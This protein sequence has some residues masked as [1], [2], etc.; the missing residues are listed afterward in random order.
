[1]LRILPLC[2]IM[3][4]NQSAAKILHDNLCPPRKLVLQ[5]FLEVLFLF[6]NTIS[7]SLSIIMLWIY[8]P[9]V[10]ISIQPD[11]D[12]IRSYFNYDLSTYHPIS[13]TCLKNHP[14]FKLKTLCNFK[15]MYMSVRREGIQINIRISFRLGT[16]NIRN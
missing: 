15:C 13:P 1:M 6:F 5:A 11:L 9:F 16:S 3:S 10:G 2:Q 8:M 12:M 14:I 4:S 7:Q